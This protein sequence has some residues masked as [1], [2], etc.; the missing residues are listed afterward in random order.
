MAKNLRES[1]ESPRYQAL[2]HPELPT[3]MASTA[4]A[5]KENNIP[6]PHPLEQF[7]AQKSRQVDPPTRLE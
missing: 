3:S 7:L 2:N 6:Y 1:R 5:R 4:G